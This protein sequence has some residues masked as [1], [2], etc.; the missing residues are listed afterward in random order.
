MA[1]RPVAPTAPVLV[2]E[3][4]AGSTVLGPGCDQH[5]GRN[6]LSG[7]VPGGARDPSHHAAPRRAGTP[8]GFPPGSPLGPPPGSPPSPLPGSPRREARP[9]VP[10]VVPVAP[11]A[12]P[13]GCGRDPEA[14]G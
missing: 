5:V 9:A 11:V 14:G 3:T 4:E 6:P 12:A 2:L 1:E 8:P 7:T 13:A 10:G